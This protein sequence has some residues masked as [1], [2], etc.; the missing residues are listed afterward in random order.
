[1]KCRTITMN[2]FDGAAFYIVAIFL[3]T[4]YDVRADT[5]VLPVALEHADANSESVF[6]MSLNALG[7]FRVM[8]VY[9][10]APFLAASAGRPMVISQFALRPDAAL[11]TSPGTMDITLQAYLSTTSRSPDAASADFL[12]SV[13]AEN[14]E[15]AQTKVL[16][17]TL[18]LDS[19]GATGGGVPGPFDVH[20]PFLAP[21]IYDPTAGNLLLDLQISSVG[22][23]IIVTDFVRADAA[24]AGVARIL[25]ISANAV[26]ATT[27]APFGPP[28]DQT[29]LVTEFTWTLVPEPGGRLLFT[30][31]VLSVWA[32]FPQVARCWGFQ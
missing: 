11:Q 16:D 15:G 24:G 30:L 20:K 31:G 12:S 18:E 19:A 10:A 26:S 2:R 3:G 29:G 23:N 25:G 14:V 21:F 7:G 9:D 13:F 1:M 8:Q 27:T 22:A 4:I 32:A 28:F 17:G 5:I 6:P